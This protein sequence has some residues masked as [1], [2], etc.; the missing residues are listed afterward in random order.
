MEIEEKCNSLITNNFLYFRKLSDKS[1]YL[2][3][4]YGEKGSMFVVEL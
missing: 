1:K 3:T 4:T 2:D